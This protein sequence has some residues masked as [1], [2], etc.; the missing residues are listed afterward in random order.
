MN[1]LK[2]VYKDVIITKQ[3][4]CDKKLKQTKVVKAKKLPQIILEQ[5]HMRINKENKFLMM[6]KN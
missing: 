4:R 5:I 1:G 6:I 3:I 2:I